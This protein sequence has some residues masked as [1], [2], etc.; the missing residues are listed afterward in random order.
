MLNSTQGILL[1]QGLNIAVIESQI[2]VN[3]LALKK[4]GIDIEIWAL[5]VT[6]ASYEDAKSRHARLSTYGLPIRIIRGVKPAIPFSDFLNAMVLFRRLS[7]TNIKPAFI[8]CRS[9]DSAAIAVLMNLFV[10]HLRVIW[11]V[12]GD[13]ES[14]FL[15][16][17][18]EWSRKKRLFCFIKL[19]QIKFR[20]YLAERFSDGAIF[21]S[22]PIRNVL[23]KKRKD[24]HSVIIPCIADENL[25]YFDQ[26]LRNKTRQRL[27]FLTSDTVLIYSGSLEVWQCIP[28]TISLIESFLK[29]DSQNKAIVLT[30]DYERF[31]A[32]LPES[33]KSRLVGCSVS[34]TEVNQ[35]LNAADFGIFLRKHH[36][37]NWVAS[38]VKFAEYSLA[39]LAIIMTDAVE[40]SFDYAKEFRN[41]VH[42]EFGKTLQLPLKLSDVRR[43]EISR[44]AE[45]KLTHRV[46]IKKYLEIYKLNQDK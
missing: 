15:S 23:V 26:N 10:R 25:F 34:L 42:F 8:H 30:H 37:V 46:V 20:K 43:L 3:S 45:K 13:V 39:G 29:A 1:C 28:E 5:C 27:G 36:P 2:I 7:C 4:E 16:Q 6:R 33:L 9:D 38:P 35:Y 21:V 14:E 31:A 19:W 22:E 41:L 32:Y 11:D 24:L 17:K 40:Q 18:E 44:E 12:R